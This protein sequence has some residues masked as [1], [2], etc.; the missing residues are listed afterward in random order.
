MVNEEGGKRKAGRES[1]K[2]R[3][4]GRREEGRERV[5]VERKREWLRIWA[6]V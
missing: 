5:I 1:R 3:G 4:K 6:C 2:K